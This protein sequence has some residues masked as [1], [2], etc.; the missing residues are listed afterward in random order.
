MCYAIVVNAKNIVPSNLTNQT[1]SPSNVVTVGE[2]AESE[3]FPAI[4]FPSQNLENESDH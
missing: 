1:F 3:G 4:M 2:N